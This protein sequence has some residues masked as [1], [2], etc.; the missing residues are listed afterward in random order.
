MSGEYFAYLDNVYPELHTGIPIALEREGEVRAADVALT[1]VQSVTQLPEQTTEV[2][3]AS[4]VVQSKITSPA[5]T[6]DLRWF[7]TTPDFNTAPA[8]PAGG[9]IWTASDAGTITVHFNFEP[10]GDVIAPFLPQIGV[11]A[12][13]LL[14][15]PVETSIVAPPGQFQLTDADEN[16]IAFTGGINYALKKILPDQGLGLAAPMTP[17]VT[18]YGNIV[19]ATRGESA[20]W[21]VLGVGNGAVAR[22]SFSL[23]KKPL[24]YMPGPE[25][26]LSTLRVYVDGVLWPEVRSFYGRKPE[27]EVYIAR[28]DDQDVTTITFNPRLRTGALVAASYR[29]GAGLASPP[30]GSIKQI[31]KPVEGLRGVRNPIAAF[32]GDDREAASGL[33]VYAPRSALLLGR[34]ISLPDMEA[35]AITTGGV[36]AARAGWR[37]NDT[38]QTAVVQIWYIGAAPVEELVLNRLR[39]LSDGVT[40][41]DVDPAQP[42]PVELSISI[43]VDPKRI[44]A[45]V[46][47]AVGAALLTPGEGL[48]V[49]ERIGIGVPLFRSRVFEAVLAVPGVTAVT[50][51]LWNG[52]PWMA[53]GK[54]PQAGKYFDFENGTVYVNGE[55]Q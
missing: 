46:I 10:G 30:A 17:P 39:G 37:W 11:G 2:K 41:I 44:Q 53:F 29:F 24:T 8:R 43:G 47:A 55:A 51:L 4:N 31:A 52:A 21:E 9:A 36:R 22:Q 49:P 16:A 32:G 14:A 50:G 54:D 45:D 42:A 12:P 40:P 33:R 23:K 48:L 38:S 20:P 19:R 34:A 3:D 1:N 25:E 13:L 26:P 7:Y 15:P 27:E 5:V 28:Q 18:A 6:Q 35:A